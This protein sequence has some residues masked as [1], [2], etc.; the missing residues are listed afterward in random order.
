VLVFEDAS[1]NGFGMSSGPLN[2]EGTKFVVA[3]LAKFHAASI[4]LDRDV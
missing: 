4:Y 2:L 3:K 1:V